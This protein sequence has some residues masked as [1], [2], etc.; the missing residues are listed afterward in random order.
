MD[1]K[2]IDDIAT[3]LSEIMPPEMK[4]LHD[5]TKQQMSQVLKAQLA[6]LDLVTREE[7]DV[8]VKVLQKTR[9]KLTQLEAK[10]AEL[11]NS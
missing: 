5:Q 8:Q 6:K 1:A 10:L 2:I 3:K 11:E 7:F 4:N 9:E